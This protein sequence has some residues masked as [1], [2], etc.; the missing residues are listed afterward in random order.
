MTQ[1][2]RQDQLFSGPVR[3]MAPVSASGEGNGAGLDEPAAAGATLAFDR[4]RFARHAR[5][6][7]AGLAIDVAA[8]DDFGGV[9]LL[10]LPDTNILVL[11]AEADLAVAKDGAGVLA[12]T[13]VTVAL[14]T[15]AATGTALSGAESDMLDA[16]PLTADALEVAWRAH[17]QANAAPAPLYVPDG[18]SSALYLNAA[19]TVSADGGLT[20]SGTVDLYYVDLGNAAG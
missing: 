12:A 3:F 10:G 4:A 19:A 17:T 5:V 6:A 9:E 20:V 15:A 1:K 2:T 7:V 13:D 14:G 8:A 16:L 18:P 11:G